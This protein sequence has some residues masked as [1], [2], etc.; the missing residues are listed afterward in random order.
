MR[1]TNLTHK[2]RRFTVWSSLTIVLGAQLW[3]YGW[4]VV[5]VIVGRGPVLG[6]KGAFEIEQIPTPV[7]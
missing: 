7:H 6:K 4:E 5:G 2:I 1:M 3:E